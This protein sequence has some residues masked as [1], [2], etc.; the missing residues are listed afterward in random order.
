MRIAIAIA[1]AIAL[2]ACAVDETISD[3]TAEVS[4]ALHQCGVRPLAPGVAVAFEK[5]NGHDRALMT[6]D[7][8]QELMSWKQSISMWATCM[9]QAGL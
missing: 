5:V 2:T 8:Y 3:D 9:E 6:P 4:S 1:I 7:G